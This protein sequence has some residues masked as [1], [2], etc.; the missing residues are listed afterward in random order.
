M[1]PGSEGSVFKSLV[2]PTPHQQIQEI[3][4]IG[5][6]WKGGNRH[7]VY[8]SRGNDDRTAQA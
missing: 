6:F 2:P 7:E 5:F 1:P 4:K 3:L 8:T